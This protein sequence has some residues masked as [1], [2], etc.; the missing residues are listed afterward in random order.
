MICVNTL[1]NN[2][3]KSQEKML[4]E[5]A[6]KMEEYV[7]FG[8][9]SYSTVLDD[10]KLAS[11]YFMEELQQDYN[12]SRGTAQDISFTDKSGKAVTLTTDTEAFLYNEGFIKWL[13]DEY[14]FDYSFGPSS[15]DW[16]EEAAIKA[17]YDSKF[18][19]AVPEV[20]KYWNTSVQLL[21]YFSFLEQ[22]AYFESVTN[23]ITSVS[24][25]KYAN[26]T[27]PVTVNGVQR[28]NKFGN[29]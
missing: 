22:Q 10:Y 20:V 3:N 12:N 9:E 27:E 15:K 13:E 23:K 8:G 25:I 16:T 17:I 5:L 14:K 2:L 4:E 7:A 11:K 1:F 6:V 28:I 18:P 24:G 29:I 21:T 19:M 26:F